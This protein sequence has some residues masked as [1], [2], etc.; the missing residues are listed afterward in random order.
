V[1][2]TA[3]AANVKRLFLTH[4]DPTHND[5]FL[6]RIEERSRETA[7]SPHSPMQVCC[8]Y[9]WCSWIS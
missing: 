6:N 4:H 3:A 9:T 1:I 7:A 8:A 2:G 5:D